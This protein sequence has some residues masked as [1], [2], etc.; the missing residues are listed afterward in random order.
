M[1]KL[2]ANWRLSPSGIGGAHVHAKQ[3]AA[4]GLAAAVGVL[5]V[6]RCADVGVVR[7]AYVQRGRRS[8]VVDVCVH[9]QRQ[10]DQVV[11]KNSRY[12]GSWSVIT[13]TS[14]SGLDPLLHSHV[15]PENSEQLP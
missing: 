6:A 12:H 9:L 10:K 8:E 4:A 2:V 3:A 15:K 14:T 7:H 5:A 11:L 13:Y 1:Q